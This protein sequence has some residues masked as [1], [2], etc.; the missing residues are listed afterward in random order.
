M[1]ARG[2]PRMIAIEATVTRADGTVEHLG[3]VSYWHANPIR[4]LAWRLGRWLRGFR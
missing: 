1:L 4:R 2:K 3:V